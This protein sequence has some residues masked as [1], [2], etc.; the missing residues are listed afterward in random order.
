MLGAES[1]VEPAFNGVVLVVAVTVA[2]L[3]VVRKQRA[4]Q[5]KAGAA[6]QGGDVKRSAIRAETRNGSG[7][8]DAK[9]VGEARAR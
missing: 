8:P 7:V 9:M 1:Y 3:G 2:R 6:D 5:A 4:M